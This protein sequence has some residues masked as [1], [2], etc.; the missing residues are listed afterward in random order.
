MRSEQALSASHCGPQL[1]SES[2]RRSRMHAPYAETATAQ[3]PDASGASISLN[4]VE[5]RRGGDC[6][7]GTRE[8]TA[9]A[10][11]ILVVCTKFAPTSFLQ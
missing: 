10:R 4:T 5:S 8:A 2:S 11:F 3:P 7:R 9:G 1:R 6:I